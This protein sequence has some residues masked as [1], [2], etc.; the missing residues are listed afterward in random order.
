MKRKRLIIMQQRDYGP[1]GG[2]LVLHSWCR[3]D[4]VAVSGGV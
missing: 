2:L 3:R 1:C 4:N